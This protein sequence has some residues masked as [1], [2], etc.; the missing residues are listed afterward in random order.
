MASP[1]LVSSG[2]PGSC[3]RSKRPSGL[4]NTTLWARSGGPPP[5]GEL[6]SCVCSCHATAP[7]GS[8]GPLLRGEGD[9]GE[10]I[11]VVPSFIQVSL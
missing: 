10:E 2:P 7:D 9:S 8:D 5:S 11:R 1:Y 4:V 3:R 6:I